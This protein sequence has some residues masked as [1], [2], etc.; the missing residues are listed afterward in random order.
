MSK[1]KPQDY[2]IENYQAIYEHYRDFTPDPKKIRF[3]AN[4]LRLIYNPNVSIS[5]ETL[6]TI[7]NHVDNGDPIIYALNHLKV[8]DQFVVGAAIWSVNVL[9]KN[10]LQGVTIPAKLSYYD[11]S[12]KLPIPISLSE[13]LGMLPTI[14]ATDLN[15]E[16]SELFK[17]ATDGLIN[18]CAHQ[19]TRRINTQI[20]SEGARNKVDPYRI[21]RLKTGT[22]RIALKALE[23]G[24]KP[25]ILPSIVWYGNEKAGFYKPDVHFGTPIMPNKTET[26]EEI[27]NKL[28]RNM[29]DS[30]D[31]IA[32]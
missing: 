32:A 17:N 6:T 25:V 23:L 28:Q 22:A 16:D 13:Q 24:A 21:Q 5:D 12:S 30:L 7:T 19:Q 15:G 18:T 3:A 20:A 27:T 4:V 9:R 31:L 26:A 14:R 8:R 2:T 11:G 29:Q 1:L 10:L